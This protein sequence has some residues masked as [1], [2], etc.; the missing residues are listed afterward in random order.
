[1]DQW[2]EY[3]QP[4]HATEDGRRQFAE[5]LAKKLQKELN[6]RRRNDDTERQLRDI[7]DRKCTAREAITDFAQDDEEDDDLDRFLERMGDGES[8]KASAQRS[9]R[10][11]LL[12]PTE[13]RKEPSRTKDM[14]N[15]FTRSEQMFSPSYK[16]R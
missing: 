2:R 16:D 11:T 3:E 9:P 7:A 4:D 8:V 5:K 10:G 12:S 14:T 6:R 15:S 1:M 13:W